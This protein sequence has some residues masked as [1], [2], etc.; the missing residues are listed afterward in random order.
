[1]TDNLAKLVTALRSG[2]YIQG[3]SAL[4]VGDKFC[5]LGVA[6][7]LYAKETGRGHWKINSLGCYEFV[8]PEDVRSGVLPKP[9]MEWLGLPN[10]NGEFVRDGRPSS[11]L[12]DM[13]D[14][15][16]SFAAIADLIESGPNWCIPSPLILH[17]SPESA[18]GPAG[19]PNKPSKGII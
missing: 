10:R 11:S 18:P 9:V 17:S 15:G 8:T 5:C 4:H 13:N 16:A 2:E 12:A 3:R 1:M 6:C 7:D 14:Y 19:Q